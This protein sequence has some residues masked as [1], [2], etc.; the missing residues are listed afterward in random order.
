MTSDVIDGPAR[1]PHDSWHGG[2]P[3]VGPRRKAI[4]MTTAL[5]DFDRIAA[6]YIAMWN[7]SD[8]DERRTLIARVCVEDVRYTDPL[9]DV[10]GREGLEATIAAV[11]EQFPGFEFTLLGAVDAH[12]DQ[13]RFGWELGPAAI[14]APVAG[15][16]VVTTDENGKVTRVLGFL[17]RVP[18]A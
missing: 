7:A 17:D 13:A 11:Q 9:V 10:S 5:T 2:T 1:H 18:S 12:H 3:S 8:P 14:P 6:D 15:F 4:S 16:D